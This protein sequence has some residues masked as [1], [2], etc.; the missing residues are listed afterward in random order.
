MSAPPH[1]IAQIEKAR[2]LV[3]ERQAWAREIYS[4]EGWSPGA[5][6]LPVMAFHARCSMLRE[7]EADLRKLEAQM[8]K[9]AA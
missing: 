5:V 3:V 1:L 6:I 2:A 9:E 4:T 8:P 7:A